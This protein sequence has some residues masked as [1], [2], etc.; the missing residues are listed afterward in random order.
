MAKV[1]VF[2]ILSWLHHRTKRPVRST[3][4]ART[5]AAGE[6][7]NKK[8]MIFHVLSEIYGCNISLVVAVG[9][10]DHYRAVSTRI[11]NVAKS[12]ST[13]VNAFR[14]EFGGDSLNPIGWISRQSNLADHVRMPHSP[15]T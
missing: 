14:C 5:I 15:L 12:V 11:N 3:D 7:V 1:S 8:I 9:F 2:H 10:K 4:A 13:D 6:V